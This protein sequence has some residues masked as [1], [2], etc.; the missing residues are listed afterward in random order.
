LL[1]DFGFV[2]ILLLVSIVVAVL[3]PL[4]P[5]I[6]S[7][8]GIVP[9]NPGREKNSTYESGMKPTGQAWSQFNFRYYFFALLFVVFDILTVFLY[10]WAVNV[11]KLGAA[12]LIAVLAFFAAIAVAYIYAWFK[13]ALEWK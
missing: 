8:F 3:L 12:G 13:K 5:L 10:P 1:G 6:L 9:R 4:I 7:W 11:N 2:G